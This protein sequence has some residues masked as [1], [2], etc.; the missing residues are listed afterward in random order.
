MRLNAHQIDDSILKNRYANFSHSKSDAG[1]YKDGANDG[2]NSIC[3][4]SPP[5][6][7][8]M[9]LGNPQTLNRYSYVIGDPVNFVDPSGLIEGPPRAGCR[10]DNERGRW[11]CPPLEIPTGG[12]GTWDDPDPTTCGEPGEPGEGGAGPSA[13]D[14]ECPPGPTICQV[15]KDYKPEV[16]NAHSLANNAAL[17]V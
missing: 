17:R 13:P 1:N 15:Q 2:L 9:R 4:V 7:G 12:G 16:N 11:D 6:N 10:Y 5:Y 8:S 3:C 14:N